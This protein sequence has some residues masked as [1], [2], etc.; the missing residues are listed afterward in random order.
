MHLQHLSGRP[1]NKVRASTAYSCT[2][3]ARSADGRAP[4]LTDM[5]NCRVKPQ[6]IV[7]TNTQKIRQPNAAERV[8]RQCYF[9]AHVKHALRLDVAR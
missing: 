2:K 4:F 9:H 8:A 1:M 5:H 6:S 7:N 3:Q